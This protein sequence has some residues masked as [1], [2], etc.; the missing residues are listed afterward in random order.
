MLYVTNVGIG[1]GASMSLENIFERALTDPT[2]GLPNVP[3]FRIVRDWEERRA[4][5]R[6]Y[7]VRVIK[8]DVEGGSERDR[9]QLSWRLA[10]ELRD[11]DLI[12]SQGAS[13]YCILVTSPDAEHADE[14]CDRV[15]TI[16]ADVNRVAALKADD[17][18][19]PL[20]CRL[21][22]ASPK[23]DDVPLR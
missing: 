2:T 11:S 22:I 19:D 12:A 16:V 23:D 8:V 18:Q 1:V 7:S 10:H 3:Y 17:G 21:S 14:I 6:S 4:R 5:R 20:T 9:R 13:H 15:E